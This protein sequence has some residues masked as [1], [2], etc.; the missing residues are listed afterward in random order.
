MKIYVNAYLEN[1]LGDDLFIKILT[2]RYKKHK[3]Y[4]ITKGFKNY[5]KNN[6]KVYSNKYIFKVLKKFELEKYLANK[7]DL[8]ITI[9]GSMYQENNDNNRDFSLR[10]K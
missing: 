2:E 8:V 1:N 3:F 5:T 6:F 10:K 4:S 7:F 9:G